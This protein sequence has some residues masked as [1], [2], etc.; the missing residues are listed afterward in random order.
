MKFSVKLTLVLCIL[1]LL[2]GVGCSK[3]Q[4]KVNKLDSVHDNFYGI[5]WGEDFAFVSK[6]LALVKTKY[7]GNDNMPA[8]Q[9]LSDGFSE[10]CKIPV[11]IYFQFFNNKLNIVHVRAGK[12]YSEN[13][14]SAV[15][16]SFGKPKA[17]PS[18][19]TA[20]WQDGVSTIIMQKGVD[21]GDCLLSISNND[22]YVRLTGK[23]VHLF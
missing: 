3:N 21:D 11:L 14:A 6:M 5:Q 13:L 23:Q 9:V 12:M 17:R 10:Y 18:K 8:Y 16:E 19:N 7:G 4:D 1:L 15:E 2:V 20:V 22:N